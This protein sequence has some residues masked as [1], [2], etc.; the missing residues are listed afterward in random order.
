MDRKAITKKLQTL[1]DNGVLSYTR[2]VAQSTNEIMRSVARG[3]YKFTLCKKVLFKVGES[4]RSFKWL[5]TMLQE[6]QI[7]EIRTLMSKRG[8]LTLYSVDK[9]VAAKDIA[10]FQYGGVK[11]YVV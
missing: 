1:F 5:N 10:V 7:M 11:L 8:Y 2:D 3:E 4:E 9:A 6:Q